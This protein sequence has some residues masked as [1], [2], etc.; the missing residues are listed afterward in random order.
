MDLVWEA[1]PGLGARK[2]GDL[3]EARGGI[4]LRRFLSQPHPLD[5][6]EEMCCSGAHLHRE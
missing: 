4:T 2:Y 6:A 1:A 5:R 3:E